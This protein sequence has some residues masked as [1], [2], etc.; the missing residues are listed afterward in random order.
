MKKTIQFTSLLTVFLF[1]FQWS[2]AQEGGIEFFH[3]TM[4]EAKQ[5]AAESGKLI[6]LDA[7]ATWCGP[8]KW[9]AKYSFTD[10]QVAS[11]YNENFIN[12]KMDMERGEGPNLARRL[13][14]R[15]YPTIFFLQP[16]G[17]VALKST[18]A[19]DAYGLLDLAKGALKRAPERIEPADKGLGSD[20]LEA[21][22]PAPEAVPDFTT[23]KGVEAA[24]NTAMEQHDQA[25]Y[26]AASL[27]LLELDY[28]ETAFLY[29]EVQR[30]WADEHNDPGGFAEKVVSFM[31]TQPGDDADLLNTAAWHFSEIVED[32]EMLKQAAEWAAQS[33]QMVPSYYNH[34]TFSL[35]RYRLGDTA[36]AVDYAKRAIEL[37]RISDIDYST[38]EKALAEMQ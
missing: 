38:T 15:A 37:A 33:I 1:L 36:G 9:M 32:R 24:L 7:Y 26:Q 35:L 18:G 30:A 27:A 2:L 12:V 25:G 14:I 13:G 21:A 19:K 20:P 5:K 28:T 11:F 31:K 6:F 17:E 3:G 22:E 34:D 4:Q 16:T 10:P 23:M 8:C 29:L